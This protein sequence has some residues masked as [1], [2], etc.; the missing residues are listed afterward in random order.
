MRHWH[1][2]V[3]RRGLQLIDKIDDAGELFNHIVDV[4]LFQAQSCE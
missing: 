3:C 4:L 2:I 1:H